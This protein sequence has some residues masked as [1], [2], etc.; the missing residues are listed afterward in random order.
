MSNMSPAGTR[1][2][3]DVQLAELVEAGDAEQRVAEEDLVV[4]ERERQV[5]VQGH[6]PQREFA[7]FD[8]HVV[9]VGAV[10][11]VGDDFADG[12]EVQVAAMGVGGILGGPRFDHPVGEI[13]GGRD[14]ECS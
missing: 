3:V 12:A 6:Q 9:D 10:E 1:V 11:A 8:G 13:A 5:A 4:D 14:Q 2:R 7:H